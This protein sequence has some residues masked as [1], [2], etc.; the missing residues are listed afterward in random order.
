[1]G[2]GTNYIATNDEVASNIGAKTPANPS[3]LCTNARALVMG[4]FSPNYRKGLD[5]YC[6]KYSE[7]FYTC[8]TNTTSHCIINISS[9]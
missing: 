8:G 5:N 7:P 3:Y 9:I 2:K 6:V 1:M 4:G